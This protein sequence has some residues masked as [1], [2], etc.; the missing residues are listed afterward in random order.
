MEKWYFTFGCGQAYENCFII[1]TGTREEA[2]KKMIH[3]FGI[4][5]SWQYS[6]EEWNEGGISQQERYNLKEIK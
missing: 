1:F 2:R 6:E 5:W 3:S 4:K